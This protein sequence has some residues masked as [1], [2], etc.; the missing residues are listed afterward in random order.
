[1]LYTLSSEALAAR[2]LAVKTL[3]DYFLVLGQ[4][5]VVVLDEVY[6]LVFVITA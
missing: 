2:E 5:N 3:K 1:M 4:V 6:L